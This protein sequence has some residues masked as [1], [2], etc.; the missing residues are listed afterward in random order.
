MQPRL[1]VAAALAAVGV[2]AGG[3]Y[4]WPKGRDLSACAPLHGYAGR[5]RHD[6]ERTYEGVRAQREE[7]WYD[8]LTGAQREVTFGADG[9]MTRE[10]GTIRSGE[11]ARSIWVAYPERSWYVT[12]DPFWQ[13]AQ[14]DAA[15]V[16]AQSYRE[17]V[18]RRKARIVGRALVD[19]RAALRLHETVKPLRP[20]FP[21]SSAP[22]RTFPV[23]EIDT[24][25]DPVT[26][27]PVRTRTVIGDDWTQV[28]STWL[29]R[30]AANVAKTQV[31]VPSGFRRIEPAP[32]ASGRVLVGRRAAGNCR[33]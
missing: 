12:R 5:I 4:L 26:Y 25:V 31:G 20:S 22:T 7:T 24:W 33:Q 16:V 21:G 14:P 15:A 27:V 6:V 29:P 28:D 8:S 3:Y 30:T 32:V 10:I 1:A 18:V 19:G 2:G 11:K 9:R 13:L 17:K 23:L